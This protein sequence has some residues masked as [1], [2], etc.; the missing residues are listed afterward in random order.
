MDES[1][2]EDTDSAIYH[3]FKASAP[4]RGRKPWK[5]SPTEIRSVEAELVKIHH[6]KDTPRQ[7]YQLT[8]QAE[9]RPTV[10]TTHGV[11]P[12]FLVVQQR[13]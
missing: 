3:Y 1:R 9:S 7:A 13:W 2:N 8:D 6:L 5:L 10:T 4:L 11:E 12:Q